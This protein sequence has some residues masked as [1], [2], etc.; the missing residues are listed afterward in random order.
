MGLHRRSSRF[1][2]HTRTECRQDC[3]RNAAKWRQIARRIVI[4]CPE[5]LRCKLS[6]GLWKNYREITAMT[7]LAIS[8]DPTGMSFHDLSSDGKS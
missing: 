2:S 1:H 7:Q 5:D 6:L 4:H 8:L 3:S